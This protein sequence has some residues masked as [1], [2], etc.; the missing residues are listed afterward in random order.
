MLEISNIFSGL[1][2]LTSGDGEEYVGEWIVGNQEGYGIYK[3]SDGSKYTGEW[4]DGNPHG[5]GTWE[6]SELKYVGNWEDGKRHGNGKV[7]RKKDKKILYNGLFQ[8][9]R[10]AEKQ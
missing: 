5:V 9:D 6:N 3:W 2:K 1:G 10:P 7:I 8:N 4:H